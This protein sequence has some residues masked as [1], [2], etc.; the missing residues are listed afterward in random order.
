LK[1]EAPRLAADVGKPVRRDWPANRLGSSRSRWAC[2]F[3]TKQSLEKSALMLASV[4]GALIG[5]GALLLLFF[6]F[7]AGAELVESPAGMP[8]PAHEKAT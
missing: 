1:I 6:Y 2:S 4:F 8:D 5:S 3:T 7:E